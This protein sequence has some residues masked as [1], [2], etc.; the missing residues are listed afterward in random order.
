MRRSNM[1]MLVMEIGPASVS[2]Q[3][4]PSRLTA[5]PGSQGPNHSGSV[6]V[7]ASVEVPAS[8]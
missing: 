8:T 7:A 6:N 3:T 1:T 5:V 4:I 2:C